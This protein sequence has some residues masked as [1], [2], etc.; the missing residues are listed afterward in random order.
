M[1]MYWAN[2]S[3]DSTTGSPVS[4][5]GGTTILVNNWPWFDIGP[6]PNMFD[7][8]F[9]R[10][11]YRIIMRRSLNRKK[12]MEIRNRFSWPKRWTARNREYRSR[13]EPFEEA[14]ECES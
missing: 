6:F 10:W 5:E 11:I 9:W 2:N 8:D 13:P 4:F 12:F 7:G 3:S 1:A 14:L